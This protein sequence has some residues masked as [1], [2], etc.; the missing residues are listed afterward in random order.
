MRRPSFLLP[1][2]LGLALAACEGE[3]AEQ[4]KLDDLDKELVG[5]AA[6]PAL[7]EALEDQIMVDRDLAGQQRGAAP[8]GTGQPIPPD[9]RRAQAQA[10]YA[11]K[12][13]KLLRAP[14]PGKVEATGGGAPTL[15]ELAARQKGGSM[16]GCADK[17]SYSARWAAR[18][19]ADTP[20]YPGANVVEA[21]GGDEAPCRMRVVTFRAPAAKQAILDYYYTKAVRGGYSA[22]HQSDGRE[23]V[24]GGT[25]GNDAFVLFLRDLPGG[26]T[27]VD[28][29]SNVVA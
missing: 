14:A 11:L 13:G 18:L 25:K 17:L 5:N 2:A 16:A 8:G 26:G 22:E 23:H 1:L 15:G 6:D 4:A 24:L 28:L 3:R 20:V 10:E 7:T 12:N 21:A 27:E 29:V 19:S 9:R